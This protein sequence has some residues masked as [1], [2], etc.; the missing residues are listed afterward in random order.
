MVMALGDSILAG[1]AIMGKNT[2]DIFNEYRGL[3]CSPD[4]FSHTHM[5]AATQYAHNYV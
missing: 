3:R 4:S 5:L 1:L 2:D